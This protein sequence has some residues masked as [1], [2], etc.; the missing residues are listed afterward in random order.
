MPKNLRSRIAVVAAAGYD[1][2]EEYSLEVQQIAAGLTHSVSLDEA[3]DAAAA[4]PEAVEQARR[5]SG[6]S[7]RSSTSSKPSVSSASQK[8]LTRK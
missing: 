7:V 3:T 1:D 6:S 4:I 8:R 2:S 5:G